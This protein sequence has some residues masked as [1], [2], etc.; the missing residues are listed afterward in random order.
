MNNQ[1]SISSADEYNQL[2]N[3]YQSE[4]FAVFL[5]L[6][7]ESMN[8]LHGKIMDNKTSRDDVINC[9]NN[10]KGLATAKDICFNALKENEVRFGN[11]GQDV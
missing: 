2:K 7:N 4:G 11:G 5:R 8:Q 3:M 1:S 6:I 10:M 9:V